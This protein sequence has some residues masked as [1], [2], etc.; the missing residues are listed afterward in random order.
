MRCERKY[1]VEPSQQA[2]A[3]SIF[4]DSRIFPNVQSWFSA[5]DT[6]SCNELCQP[7][8]TS[9]FYLVFDGISL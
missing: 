2:V 7:R 1:M 3:E 5:A 6:F 9:T 8:E 4:Y